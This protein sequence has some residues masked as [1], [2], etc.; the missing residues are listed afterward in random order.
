MP[1]HRVL[2]TAYMTLAKTM[3][4]SLDVS[5]GLSYPAYVILINRKSMCSLECQVHE[6]QLRSP[7]CLIR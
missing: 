2:H 3:F 1:D 4:S 6:Y 5:A 7:V